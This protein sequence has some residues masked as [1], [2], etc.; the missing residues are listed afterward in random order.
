M[1]R[2][3]PCY[4]SK[5]ITMCKIIFI[6]LIFLNVNNVFAQ[7]YESPEATLATYIN[8]LKAGNKSQVL[9][10]FY[11]K[12][13]DFYLPGPVR[14]ESYEILKKTVYSKKEADNWNSKGIIPPA[15]IGDIDLQV[16]QAEYGKKWMFSY[17]LRNVNGKWKIISHAAWDQP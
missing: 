9:D 4:W 17:L 14:I 2:H 1:D 16:E 10:C 6:I 13:V 7:N 3:K 12:L 11:P 5:E 8:A 15:M